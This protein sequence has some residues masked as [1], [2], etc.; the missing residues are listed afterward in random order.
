MLA[1]KGGAAATAELA[2]CT[3]A[4]TSFGG[5]AGQLGAATI[6]KGTGTPL[7]MAPEVFAGGSHYGPEV[8]V[9]SYGIIMWELLTRRQPWDEL[10]ATQYI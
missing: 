3:P 7:W 8:A 4:T 10:E 9:Y 6:T 5:G 1:V 2:R